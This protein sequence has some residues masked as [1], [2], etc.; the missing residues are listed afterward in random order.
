MTPDVIAAVVSAFVA[1]ASLFVALFVVWQQLRESALRRGDVLLWAN[2][3][4]TALESLLLVCMLNESQLEPAISKSKIVEL[5]FNTSILVERGRMFFKNT[6]VDDFGK[7]KESAYRGYRPLILDYIFVAYKIACEWND[8]DQDTRLR[9]RVVAEDC[10]KKFVSLVQKEVGRSV[11]A[12]A[13]VGKGGDGARLREL[14]DAVDPQQ[15]NHV[16]RTVVS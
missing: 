9:M 8:A 3:V 6:V 2:E 10:L 16:R 1:T 11:I 13:E 14:L 5:I 4:I 7:G 15:L 12:S